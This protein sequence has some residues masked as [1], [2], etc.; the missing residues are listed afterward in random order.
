MNVKALVPPLLAVLLAAGCSGPREQTTSPT[1]PSAVAPESGSAPGADKSPLAPVA[2]TNHVG[3]T[4]NQT[5]WHSGFF[6]SYWKDSGTANMTLGSAGNYSV[7]WNLGGSG[8]F[9][10][11]KGWNPG[12]S[13]R[14]VGYNAGVWAWTAGATSGRRAPTSRVS[15]A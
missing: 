14:V 15:A 2:A 11:G 10:G 1:N 8:N 12:S 13:S 4:T 6:Y 5:G 7:S 3:I 9:V